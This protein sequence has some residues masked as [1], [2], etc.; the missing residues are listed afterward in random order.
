[1]IPAS[2]RLHAIRVSNDGMV[3]A[4]DREHRRVQVFGLD[5]TFVGQVVTP[6]APFAR[7]LALS[8]DPEQQFLYVGGD[9][10]IVVVDRAT[11]EI[12]GTLRPEGILGTGHHIATDSQGNLY[13]A[14][15]GAG[16]QK[17]TFTGMPE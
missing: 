9:G 5:G 12:L 10:G 6:D 8:A 4:A 15:T 1:M 17:L 16:M 11:L 13:L 14:A 2:K 7:N 3:Y